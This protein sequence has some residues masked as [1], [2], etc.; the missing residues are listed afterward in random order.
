MS[1][2]GLNTDRE[3]KEQDAEKQAMVSRRRGRPPQWVRQLRDNF[4]CDFIYYAYKLLRTEKIP[5]NQRIAAC[6]PIYA[7]HVGIDSNERIAS[8][9]SSIESNV[10]NILAIIQ[11]ASTAPPQLYNDLN[12]TINTTS[13]DNNGIR[14][15]SMVHDET[16]DPFGF[17]D[18]G[19]A[20]HGGAAEIIKE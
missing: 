10:T 14:Y 11:Q 12:Y 19:V 1:S 5:L 16:V 9:R 6:A 4:N 8:M 7:K 17:A 15:D 3:A 2:G 18:G 20:P 13:S